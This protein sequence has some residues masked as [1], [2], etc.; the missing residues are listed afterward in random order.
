[1]LIFS[2]LTSRLLDPI[3]A[4]G[5][6]GL[7]GN[8]LNRFD[9]GV[10]VLDDLDDHWT[11]KNHK[12][13][14]RFVIED[15]QDL[16]ADKSVRITILSGDVHLAAV[17]QFY[18][19]AKQKLAKHKDFR[20]MPNII[21]SAIANTPP[22]DL[23]ADILNKRN[24][25]HHFDKETDEDM[26]PIFLHGVDGK[27]RNNKRLLPHRNWCSIR[28]YTPGL[29]PP[30]TPPPEFEITPEGTPPG[31]RPGGFL[32]RL[33]L[34]SKNRGPKVRPD[35]PRDIVD[36]SRP[37]ISG[38]G[39]GGGGGLFRSFSRRAS[40]DGS[41][42]PNKLLRTLSLGRGD[43]SASR[44][45][46]S[47]FSFGFG[48]RGSSSK[49][50]GGINGDWGP[51]SEEDEAQYDDS[52]AQQYDHPPQPPQQQ[53]YPR[54]QQQRA[55]RPG[56]FAPAPPPDYGRRGSVSGNGNAPHLRGGGNDEYEAGDDSFFTA[57]PPRRAFTQPATSSRNNEYDAYYSSAGDDDE[58][59]GG[60]AASASAAP[61]PPPMMRPFHRTPTGLSVKERRKGGHDVDLA[62]GLDV[63]LNVEV[64]AR[65]P[66][67]I[68]VPYRLLV[69]RLWYEYAGEDA[70]RAAVVEDATNVGAGVGVNA[71]EPP[72]Y[73][74]EDERDDEDDD[75]DGEEYEY[76]QEAG[77]GM[78]EGVAEEKPGL[79]KRLFSGRGRRESG[80][81]GG[82]GAGGGG[83]GSQYRARRQS[84]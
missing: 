83:G 10:E 25:V 20:Y 74:Y 3:K 61:L 79:L 42:R 48:R 36:R 44:P 1:M 24:K 37:P 15:L 17:G 12:D 72:E 46:G 45:R 6:A 56:A 2:S 26:I 47:S 9:G 65:D 78:H 8:F 39:G 81:S 35:A 58:Q 62:G 23:M 29:T 54:Q 31:S 76:E 19:N 43:S 68:T 13:E 60:G 49:D 63:C 70:G 16:A 11:A 38:G 4:L 33:S 27:P 40:S 64:N 57:R 50:D 22:P 7:L 75:D 84:P 5:K 30:S 28:E 82:A 34:S 14:R 77:P 59:G 73:E 51:D 69:P 41:S 67:G 21:S 55:Q 66:A 32:R 53:Q 71:D 18:S 80:R 52:Q